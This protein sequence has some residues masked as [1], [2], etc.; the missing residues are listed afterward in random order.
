MV[1]FVLEDIAV[2]F[3]LGSVKKG[4]IGSASFLGE[5]QQELYYAFV[6][7]VLLLLSGMA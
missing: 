6:W 2:T 7:L 3:Q 5:G 4:L 1:A